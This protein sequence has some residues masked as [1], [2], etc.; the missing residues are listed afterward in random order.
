MNCINIIIYLLF[1]ANTLVFPQPLNKSHVKLISDTVI[2]PQGTFEACHASTIVETT[3][4][5]FVAAWFAG[6]R[7][8]A[9]NVGIWLSTFQG[10]KR[11]KPFEVAVGKDSTGNQVPCW[12]PVLFKTK[13]NT[14]ILFYKVG[15]NPR[16][17]WG[18]MIR[19]YDNGKSWSDPLALPKGFL[20]PIKDKPI[21]LD[22][23]K[24]LCPS[25]IESIDGEWSVH[26]EIT[27]EGLTSWKKINIEKDSTVG[28]IQPTI[29]K[30]SDGNLQMLCRSRQNSI[31]QT[32]SMDNGLHWS[33]LRKT[34]LPNPN[35]GIDAVAMDSGKFIL[36]YNP[37]LH[38]TK[39]FNGRNVLNIALSDDGKNWGNIYQL[40]NEKDGEFSYPAVIQALD[41]TIHITYTS[42][43]KT[44]KHFILKIDEE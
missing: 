6:S 43:R 42:R 17:W 28:V 19:S 8:G 20:G 2:F 29:I 23:G 24:I 12:N 1:I 39:W 10:N 31:Y 36:V 40:E 35:S 38:G 13:S 22:N 9:K 16:E 33:K 4:G 30:H 27:N 15:I 21:Q 32:W 18:S 25:S 37:L 11:S 44:I 14:L 7:E 26:L 3:P 5:I 41:K 34:S